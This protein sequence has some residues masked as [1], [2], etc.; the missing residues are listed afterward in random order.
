MRAGVEQLGRP[1]PPLNNPWLF[2]LLDIWGYDTPEYVGTV[3]PGGAVTVFDRPGPLWI[4][5]IA[6]ET[7]NI[8]VAVRT[9]VEAGR[10]LEFTI[11][12]RMLK[13]WGVVTPI[14]VGPFLTLY[15]ESPPY[16][17]VLLTPS[18]WLPVPARGRATIV[19]ANPTL[20]PAN[21]RVRTIVMELLPQLPSPTG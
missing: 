12:P 4:I 9:R 14:P 7:D 11:T 2:P 15:Q 10:V 13:D 18:Q 20:S 8:D 3:P 1:L 6:G 5:L 16:A 17:V 19:V 21:I